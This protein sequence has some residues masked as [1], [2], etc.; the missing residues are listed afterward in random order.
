MVCWY[1]LLG[2]RHRPAMVCRSSAVWSHPG[3]L[4]RDG[5]TVNIVLIMKGGEQE[6]LLLGLL[7]LLGLLLALLLLSLSLS[8]AGRLALPFCFLFSVNAVH[9]L[10]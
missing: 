2:Q 3:Q 10:C 4:T 1:V 8:I 9:L 5:H 6:G 7:C